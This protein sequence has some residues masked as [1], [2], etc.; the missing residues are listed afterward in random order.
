MKRILLTLGLA[1][2]AGVAA[3][4]AQGQGQGQLPFSNLPPSR[5]VV[6]PYL[7]LLNQQTP[8]ISNYF[9]LVKP[10]IE[11]RRELTRQQLELDRL[12]HQVNRARPA[13]LPVQGSKEIRGTGHETVFMNTLHFYP[14]RAR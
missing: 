13:G 2:I 1:L 7:Q 6:S 4:E 3:S 5:P 14:P 11:A 12:Q 10:Q 9:T 8:G